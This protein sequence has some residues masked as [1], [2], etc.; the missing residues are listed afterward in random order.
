MLAGGEEDCG[1]PCRNQVKTG[2]KFGGKTGKKGPMPSQQT[3]KRSGDNQVEYGIGR[4]KTSGSKKGQRDDLNGVGGQSNQP[5]Q[6]LLGGLDRFQEV[7][8]SHDVCEQD[9]T[10]ERASE[11][12]ELQLKLEMGGPG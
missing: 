11:L 9:T 4:R 1:G 8:Q 3:E 10:L 7:K 12:P 5:C 6:A 2:D